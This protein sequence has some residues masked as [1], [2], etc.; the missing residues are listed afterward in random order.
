MSGSGAP[1]LPDGAGSRSGLDSSSRTGSRNGTGSPN[2]RGPADRPSLPDA[3]GAIISLD[4]TGDFSVVGGLSA[5]AVVLFDLDD[6]LFAHR[7]AVADGIV[8][9]LRAAGGPFAD[10][11]PTEAV[12]LWHALEEEHY[13][14]YLAGTLDFQGQRRA[15]VRDFAAAHGVELA[16]ADT[17]PWFERYFLRYRESWHLHDDALPCLEALA[18]AFPGIRFGLITNGDLAYQREKLQA[19]GLDSRVEHVIASGE[20]GF[21]KPDPRIFAHACEAFGVAAHAAVYVGD[22]L[23]T[24]AIG[25]AAAGLTGV[26]L[27]RHGAGVPEA[28]A[29]EAQRLGVIRITGLASLTAALAAAAP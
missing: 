26:W 10:A 20:L 4:G 9:H 22:R 24:D 13:H 12:T 25:A 15:R 5:P 1:S 23:S 8:R 27:D 19:T 18:S 28:D 29:A 2:G 16:E 17:G 6:T 7:D 3:L 14:S 21:A 11:D